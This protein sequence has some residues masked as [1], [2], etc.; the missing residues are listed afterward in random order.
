MHCQQEFRYCPCLVLL[1]EN[2]AFQLLR[3]NQN[4]KI[5]VVTVYKNHIIALKHLGC[6]LSDQELSYL[7]FGLLGCSRGINFLPELL[8]EYNSFILMY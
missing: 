1:L 7:Y 8:Q 5:N 6:V 4:L 2:I 3:Q